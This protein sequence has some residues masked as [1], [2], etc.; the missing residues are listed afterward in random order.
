MGTCE[1]ISH[2]MKASADAGKGTGAGMKKKKVKGS[3]GLDEGINVLYL[4]ESHTWV[5]ADTL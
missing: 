3:H 2:E 5:H 1:G 4:V